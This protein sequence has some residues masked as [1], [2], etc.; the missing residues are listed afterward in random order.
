MRLFTTTATVLLLGLSSA[1]SSTEHVWSSVAWIL[2]G[3]STP[4]WGITPSP[5]LTPIGAQQ[6]FAQ[7]SLL[8]SRYLQNLIELD[9]QAGRAPIVG[10]ERNAIDNTQLNILTNT[11]EFMVT[12]AQAFAQGLYPPLLQTF[13]DSTG[14]IEGAMLPNGSTVNY[15]LGGYQ[16]PSIRT[17][18]ILDHES[19]WV[20][21]HVGCP[22]YTE[23]I[24]NFRNDSVVSTMYESTLPFYTNMWDSL[25]SK[26]FPQS[27]ANFAN[28][29]LLYD[30]ALYRYNHDNE[31]RNSVSL[32]EMALM[33]RFASTEQRA[34]NA[35]L[36]VSGTSEGDMIRAIAGRTMAS[37]TLALFRENM[38]QG[39]AIRKL[40]LAFTTVE[41][42][43]AFFALS[44]LVTGD[45][46][47][48]FKPLPEQG[49]MMVF[50]LFSIGGNST[51]Y[52]S[53]DDLWVR[54][55]YRNGTDPTDKLQDF[56]LWGAKE[57]RM[58]YKTFASAIQGVGINTIADWC[59]T[60]G[61]YTLFCSGLKSTGK[62]GREPVARPGLSPAVGGVIG[63]VVTIAVVGLGLLAAILLGGFRF[64]RDGEAKR[65]SSF[66]GF[67]GAE[68][69]TS[70]TDLAFA[71]GGARQERTGSWELRGE[72]KSDG[73][74]HEQAIIPTE[75]PTSTGAVSTSG[76][77]IEPRRLTHPLQGVDDDA[78]SE[79]GQ[80]PVKPREF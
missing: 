19:I 9:E 70:D 39:G 3:E 6:M 1:Q 14:G 64:R 63:A 25:L 69:M 34:K 56:S 55:L 47:A 62:G 21:G 36:S 37:K 23:S 7:G 2:H 8:R 54:F 16:Y 58:P 79:V 71:R 24:L 4:I 43:V 22:A 57:T 61:S 44:G 17:Y 48:E 78:I 41:T 38:R 67:K 80:H 49:G 12:S 51:V 77:T 50:E 66:G 65:T 46:A 35:D 27:M 32:A 60:C 29:F 75:R 68:K 13:S 42:F 59:R 76:L 28:A 10:I 45:H 5:A 40:N 26:A 20:Q 15:P 11:D 73:S 30:Y 18:S 52:P 33:A 74:V 53:T 31:T 72:G